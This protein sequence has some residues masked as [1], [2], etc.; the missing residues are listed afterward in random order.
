MSPKSGKGRFL[1]S[2]PHSTM[3]NHGVSQLEIPKSWYKIMV[4]NH[5]TKSWYKIMV[6]NHGT[7]SW[8]KIM[9]QNHGT[10]SWY[11][12]MGQNHRV[13]QLEIPI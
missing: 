4:Q 2:P 5:G 3:E 8:Y 11:K 13:S 7:K 6:Q 9:V 1:S 10:K 12:I